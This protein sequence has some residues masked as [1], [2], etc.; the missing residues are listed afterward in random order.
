MTGVLT[1]FAR[2]SSRSV[3]PSISGMFMS[4]T[5]TAGGSRGLSSNA[6]QGR[7]RVVEAPHRITQVEKLGISISKLAFISR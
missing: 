5:M 1:S 7:L 6:F 3:I 2:S 4:T